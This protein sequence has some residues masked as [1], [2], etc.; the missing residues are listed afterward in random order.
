M[1]GQQN[2]VGHK[3][4]RL[5]SLPHNNILINI[6]PPLLGLGVDGGWSSNIHRP[7]QIDRQVSPRQSASQ[8]WKVG[9][10][11]I[12][13]LFDEGPLTICKLFDGQSQ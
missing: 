7:K 9:R 8:P 4:K 3:Q 11:S 13:F 10:P 1:G 12:E 6:H 5:L 2:R